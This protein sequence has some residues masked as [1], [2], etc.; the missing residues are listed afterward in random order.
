MIINLSD[1]EYCELLPINNHSYGCYQIGVLRGGRWEHHLD[2]IK[3]VYSIKGCAPTIHTMQGG[4]RQ[5]K[6]LAEDIMNENFRIRKLTPSECWHLMGM[7]KEDCQKA[8]EIGVSDS[9]LYKIAGNGLVTNCVQE[10]F[11]H[12][13]K[14]EHDENYVCIDEK[15]QERTMEESNANT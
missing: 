11:E 15:Y 10:I 3:R 4:Q 8:R 5:P 14:A 12:L 2:I 6:I 9:Q 13:Y 1:D 7:T